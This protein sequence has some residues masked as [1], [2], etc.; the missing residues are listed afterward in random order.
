MDIGHNTMAIDP[1]C[2]M[3]VDPAKASGHFDHKGKTHHFCSQHCLRTFQGDPEQHLAVKKETGK[4]CCGCGGRARGGDAVPA[5]RVE[6]AKPAVAK[7]KYTCP[8]HPE[9]VQIGPG[10]CPKCGM[11]LVPI[12]RATMRN[13]K[14][15]LFFAFVYNALGVPIAA[16][17]LYPFF[18][19]LLSP[20][21][22]GAAM[23]M[24]SVS[25]VTNALRLRRVKL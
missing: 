22:A 25:V 14:Q 24:S 11:A 8:M 6:K 20:I 18:G 7:G 19:I 4:G 17:V 1:V 21:P 3:T 12:S 23:A 5:P 13:V 9:I 16:G 15:S 10:S 2:G